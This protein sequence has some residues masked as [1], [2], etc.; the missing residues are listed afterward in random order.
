MPWEI[1]DDVEVYAKHAWPLL[2]ARPAENTIALTV[3]ETVRADHRWSDEAMVFGW[4]DDGQVSGAVI[5]IPTYELVL[6]VIPDG[7]VDEL[8]A[9][10]HARE[11]PVPGVHGEAGVVE[12]FAAAWIASTSLRA[13]TTL[14]LRLYALSALR[15]AAAS[16]AGRARP[17]RGEDFNLAVRWLTAFH[18]ETGGPAVD[19]ETDVR[20]RIDNGLLWVWQDPTGSVVSLAGR[21]ATAAGV[22]RVARCTR[23]RRTV[24]VDMALR[25]LLPAPVTRFAAVPS[26]SCCSPISPIPPP[27]RSTSESDIDRSATAPSCGSGSNQARHPRGQRRDHGR[28]ELVQPAAVGRRRSPPLAG[29]SADRPAALLGWRSRCRRAR[30]AN[31]PRG[32]GQRRHSCLGAPVLG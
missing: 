10:L 6:A 9:E 30:T 4:Y 8:A 32:G 28:T 15:P 14:H 24:G 26:R 3:I 11:V 17:A 31:D 22:A 13:T 5:M 23:H 25:S 1:T 27:T 2:V 18:S 20:N 19:L 12:R 7:S 29:R 16:P 21:R